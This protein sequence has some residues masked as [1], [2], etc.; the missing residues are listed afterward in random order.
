MGTTNRCDSREDFQ[1][2]APTFRF[3]GISDLVVAE[4]WLKVVKSVM[5]LFLITYVEKVIYVSYILKGDVR[6]S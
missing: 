1:E 3:S 6:Y 4:E 2:H 5:S